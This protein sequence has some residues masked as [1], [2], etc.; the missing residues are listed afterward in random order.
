[1]YP[2]DHLEVVKSIYLGLI[3]DDKEN[4]RI[5]HYIIIEKLQGYVFV[6]TLTYANTKL[7]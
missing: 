1:M 2:I 7:K 3:S 5:V 6:K 4:E